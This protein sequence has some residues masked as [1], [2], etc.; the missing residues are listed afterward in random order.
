MSGQKKQRAWYSG[1]KKRH[2]MKMQLVVNS[3]TLMIMSVATGKGAMHDLRLL[4]TSGVKFHPETAFLGD[5]GYQGIQHDHRYA[6]TPNKAT[7]AIALSKEARY[8][9]RVLASTRQP[10]EHAIRRL[11][12]FRILKEVYRHRRRRF[13]LR[14]HLI[15]AICNHTLS[16]AA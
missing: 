13:T 7:K 2:T 16:I 5:A 4:R 3:A 6:F 1:K 11:K 12:I 14:V 9:N 10:V 8:E 15:A